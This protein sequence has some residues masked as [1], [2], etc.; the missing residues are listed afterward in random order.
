[1][2][3]TD[4]FHSALVE[5]LVL[6]DEGR[7]HA[8][9]EFQAD[10]VNESAQDAN[11]VSDS[12]ETLSVEGF[13]F[14]PLR[15]RLIRDVGRVTLWSLYRPGA[16]PLRLDRRVGSRW[17]RLAEVLRELDDLRERGEKLISG[18]LRAAAEDR[19]GLWGA[20]GG[21]AERSEREGSVEGGDRPSPQVD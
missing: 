16:E 12:D 21:D 1:V 5:A 10:E 3:V 2:L 6:V 20:E 8:G 18:G 14:R 9:V 7:R 4:E 17:E 15:P 11:P 19:S 13:A